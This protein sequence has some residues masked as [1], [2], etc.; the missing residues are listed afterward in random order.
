MTSRVSE[1]ALL[2][3]GCAS[4]LLRGGGATLVCPGGQ[5]QQVQR[6]EEAGRHPGGEQ[7]LLPTLCH[8]LVPHTEHPHDSVARHL[9]IQCM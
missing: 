1:A 3:F 7:H 2:T 5:A 6:P 9:S 4:G 8:A